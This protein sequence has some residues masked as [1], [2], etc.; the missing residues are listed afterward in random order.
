MTRTHQLA[1]MI[2]PVC[3]CIGTLGCQQSDD[4]EQGEQSATQQTETRTIS[5]KPQ[6]HKQLPDIE[7]RDEAIA[8]M[9]ST[10]ATLRSK[11]T[12]DDAELNDVHMT[13]YSLEKAVAYFVEHSTGEQQAAA[14]KMAE[15]VEN[16]HLHSERYRAEQTRAA[17]NEYFA[18]EE[19]F[20]VH[21]ETP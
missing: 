18:L 12:L 6:Q 1:L 3:V 16:V 7:S 10:T 2:F 17:L 13:T 14:S 21:L 20:R 19:A 15:V 11:E 8:V 9:R 4:G 5:E